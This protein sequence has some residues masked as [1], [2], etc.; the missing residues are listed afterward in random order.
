MSDLVRFLVD[1]RGVLTGELFYQAG[2]VV[3][4][5]NAPALV[6]AGRAEYVKEEPE[7]SVVITKPVTRKPR[8][9]AVKNATTQAEKD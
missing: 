2:A 6:A 4:V 8:G 3:E 9:K 7:E 5:D 1:Y